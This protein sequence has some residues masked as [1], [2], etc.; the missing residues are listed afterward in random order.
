MP[1]N[2]KLDEDDGVESATGLDEALG[3]LSVGSRPE[4]R[5]HKALYNAFYAAMLPQLKE[6][7]PGLKL[8]QYQERIFEAWKTSP[9]N[10][11]N[12]GR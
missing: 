5:N 9:E 1:I 6:E 4:E 11:R 8:S 7:L 10:P 12:A 3:V 2:N